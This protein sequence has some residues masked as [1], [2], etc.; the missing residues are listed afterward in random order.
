M[1]HVAL[2]RIGLIGFQ[3]ET[4]TFASRPATLADFEAADAWPGLCEGVPVLAAVKGV[5]LPAAGFLEAAQ[6]QPWDVI[7]ILW[8]SATPSGPVTER[9][10]EE[11][12]GRI[13]AM[14]GRAGPLD[15]LYLDL[16]GAMV[17]DHL[18]DG[19]GE[20]LRRLRDFL[21]R[22]LPVVCSLDYHANV[23]AAMVDRADCLLAYRTYPHIDMADTGR[24]AAAHLAHLFRE[25]KYHKSFARAS[26]LM[27]M[28][29]QYDASP[30]MRRIF[31]R[32]KMLEKRGDIAVISFTPGF[33]LADTPDSG[34]AVVVYGRNQ[35]ACDAATAELLGLIEAQRMA[36][37][38]KL[39]TARQAVRHA[40]MRSR[41]GPGPIILA[42]TQD[43]PGCGGN[44]DTVGL[45][46]EL[47]DQQAES[48]VL[49]LLYDP[50][51]AWQAHNIGAGRQGDFSLGAHSG[52]G[53][54][55]PVIGRF[56]VERLGDGKFTGTGPFYQ[57]C[58]MDLGPMACLRRGGVRVIL[59]SRRQQAA[60][61]AMFRHLAIEPRD[62]KILIL[63]SSVHFRADFAPIA[64][65][66]LMVDSPGENIS[67]LHELE[68][69]KCR[70]A[71]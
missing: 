43:N 65:E 23:S 48:A 11:I 27:P 21:G 39:Y 63:K 40:I 45:L 54:E 7:P 33:P 10:F 2:K 13:V 9:A 69:R 41:N 66:I 8:C 12:T 53:D 52:D 34:P 14:V 60:D 36:F 29:W 37:Q 32:I 38:G 70:L 24:R 49:G 19:E 61:Q 35:A 64:R 3:H 22:R 1:T 6:R 50:Q 30:P 4:N 15:G 18:D 25:R 56:V 46:R 57:G 55:S 47:L 5:N 17:C 71:R 16:H 67:N 68:F 31:D 51:A 58:Q 62:Q 42:D 28:I 44:S 26:Y 20:L 59:S